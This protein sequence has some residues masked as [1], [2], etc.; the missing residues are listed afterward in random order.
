MAGAADEH[1]QP[2]NRRITRVA[3]P[4]CREIGGCGAVKRT[5]PERALGTETLRAP[6]CLGNEQLQLTPVG[7]AR[8]GESFYGQWVWSSKIA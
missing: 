5:Q 6:A 4:C 3:A 1:L 8:L 7:T 2:G